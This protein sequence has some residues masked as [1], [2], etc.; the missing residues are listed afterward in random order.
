MEEALFDTTQV[1]RSPGKLAAP[2]GRV[3]LALALIVLSGVFTACAKPADPVGGDA[4][5]VRGNEL[6]VATSYD[7][8]YE[9]LHEAEYDAY[10][11]AG[12]SSREVAPMEDA[13]SGSGVFADSAQAPTASADSG[14]SGMDY[15]ATNVQVE[16]IDEADIIKTDGENI[17]VL[18]NDELVIYAAQGSDTHELSR[19]PLTSLGYPNE[20]FVADDRVAVITGS[21]SSIMPF[22]GTD[23]QAGILLEQSNTSVILFDVSDPAQPQQKT[24]LAQSGSYSASR[25]QNGVLYLISDYWIASELDPDDPATFVPLIVSGSELTRLAPDDIC[26]LPQFS[27]PHYAVAASYDFA[28]GEKLDAASVLGGASTVYMSPDNLYVTDS[29][30]TREEGEPYTDS[31]YTVVEYTEKQ[32]TQIVR[33]AL[34]D[35]GGLTLAAQATLDGRLLNQFSLD[36]YEGNLRLALTREEYQYRTL[37]D[38]SH[39]VESYQYI[40]QEPV[41]NSLIVLSP[42]LTWLGG[43]E[44]LAEDERIYSVRFTGPV[45]Y[46]VTFRQVDPLFSLDLSDP[47]QPR[48]QG[49]L[50]IP[51]FSTYLHPFSEGRLLGIGYNADEGVMEDVKLSMYDISDPYDVSELFAESTGLSYSD[52]LYDHRA[53]LVDRGQNLIGFGGDWSSNQYLVYGYDDEAGFV[54]RAHLELV[55]DGDEYWIS[56]RRGLFIGENLYVYTGTRLE[57]FNLTNFERIL[58][59][60]I[61]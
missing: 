9:A 22:D 25:L 34:D 55:T 56:S 57:V 45:G 30:Y 2:G 8:L 1:T 47:T 61:F 38:E 26:I 18:A 51:G 10:A 24:V 36:E 54:Q 15:S 29:Q 31:V 17:Y 49:E 33:L 59:L 37:T 4:G 11:Y 40:D 43:I 48:V 5:V 42:E 13:V 28:T 32:T 53:V 41:T 46:M 60:T 58:T 44:G 23:E 14:A 27:A 50:K 6:R 16:G 39:D 3:M 12:G 19:T 21:Y 52:A 20:L 35:A 7:E